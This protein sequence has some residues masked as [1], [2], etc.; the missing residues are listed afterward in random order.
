V[1]GYSLP[2]TDSF[3]R[4]L[5]ALGV[6]SETRLQGLWVVNP[7]DERRSVEKRFRELLGRGIEAKTFFLNG[8]RGRFEGAVD[9]IADE[10]RRN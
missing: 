4:Y 1:I 7:D 3:F 2:E 9:A 5:F 8:D 6:D 10:L